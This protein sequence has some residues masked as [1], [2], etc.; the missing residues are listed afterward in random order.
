[1]TNI[2]TTGLELFILIKKFVED[3]QLDVK[4]ACFGCIDGLLN[5]A[6][7][8][9]YPEEELKELANA[10]WSFAAFLTKKEKNEPTN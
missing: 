2:K 7:Q 3:G 4:E 5:L 6:N 9:N 10:C 1:M 8:N